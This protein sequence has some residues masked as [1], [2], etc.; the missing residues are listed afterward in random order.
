[1]RSFKKN[2]TFL[3]S[4]KK[5]AMFFLGTQ[6]S[7]WVRLG[8]KKEHFSSFLTLKKNAKKNTKDRNVFFG[9]ISRL[10]FEKNAKKNAAFFKRMQKNVAYRKQRSSVPNPGKR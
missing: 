4:F 10:K 1:M 7:F 5:N 6:R 8:R 3:R 2:A 9:F